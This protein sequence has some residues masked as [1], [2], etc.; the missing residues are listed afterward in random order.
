MYIFQLNSRTIEKFETGERFSLDIF[1][2]ECGYVSVQ[3]KPDPETALKMLELR[4]IMEDAS[5]IGKMKFLGV[6]TLFSG[7]GC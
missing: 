1:S 2:S 3:L 6:F 7:I 5:N 4:V